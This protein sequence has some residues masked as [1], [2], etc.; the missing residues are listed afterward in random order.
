[1]VPGVPPPP[2]PDPPPPQADIPPNTAR[3]NAVFFNGGDGATF[4]RIEF[5]EARSEIF[6]YGLAIGD[7]D[8]DGY[9]DIAVA[10]TGAASGIFFSSPTPKK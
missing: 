10:R 4:Q 1:M 9:P 7:I 3:P 6:T 5:G 2:P 8:K